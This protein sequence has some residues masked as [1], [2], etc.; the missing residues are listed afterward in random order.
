MHF[1]RNRNRPR[2]SFDIQVGRFH[3]LEITVHLVTH[4]RDSSHRTILQRKIG[5]EILDDDE[6]DWYDSNKEEINA[7]FLEL[8]EATVLS[9]MFGKELVDFHRVKTPS[10]LEQE[11]DDIG[12]IASKNK[13]GSKRKRKG[14]AA[15]SRK[16]M[17]KT[18]HKGLA[19]IADDAQDEKPEKDIY[20]S[21]GELIQLAYKKEPIRDDR[22]SRTILFRTNH[23]KKDISA[24]LEKSAEG[25]AKVSSEAVSFHNRTKL[26]HRLLVWVS[27]SDAA[28]S[29]S[30][31][32]L[33]NKAA[34]R[35]GEGIYRSEMI[36]ISSLF[37]KPKEL[38]DLS[39]D[40]DD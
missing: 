2:S 34:S 22:S 19:A 27:K 26:S 7:E 16:Q 38:M 4:R 17:N 10:I 36:P 31:G 37:R 33:D 20:F 24:S 5:G 25:N 8:L 28:V 23:E 21:F 12:G 14:N 35:P 39:D 40:E 18:K 6:W 1:F 30:E 15:T 29:A 3:L 13:I 32:G 9:R 11:N